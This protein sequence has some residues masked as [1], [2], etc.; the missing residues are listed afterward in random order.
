MKKIKNMSDFLNENV[1]NTSANLIKCG[2]KKI[3]EKDIPRYTGD[4]DDLSSY[5]S[6]N[7]YDFGYFG[8]NDFCIIHLNKSRGDD[9]LRYKD[10]SSDFIIKYDNELYMVDFSEGDNYISED[11]YLLED[12]D[13]FDDFK[14]E[15]TNQNLDFFYT[16]SF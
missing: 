8:Y 4:D 7:R 1:D 5:E 6:D 2:F 15:M 10:G 11:N 14:Q 13:N 9:V 3:S 12:E 16:V